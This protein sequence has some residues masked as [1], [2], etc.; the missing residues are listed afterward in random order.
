M[1]KSTFVSICLEHGIEPGIA[2]ENDKVRQAVRLN[3]VYWLV[4]ILTNDF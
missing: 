2:L 3:D 4:A 1:S